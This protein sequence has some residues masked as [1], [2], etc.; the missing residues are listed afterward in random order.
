MNRSPV[1][2]ILF[3]LMAGIFILTV[4]AWAQP[5]QATPLLVV[6][7]GHG[8]TDGGVKINERYQEK[9]ATL[10]IA[11]LLQNELAR[12]AAV[13]VQ[14][15]RQA[16]RLMTT[17][18]RRKAVRALQPALFISLHV[19]GGFGKRSSGYEVYFPGFGS[20]GS[21]GGG[22]TEILKDMVRNKYLNESVRLAQSLQRNLEDVFPRKGRGLREAPIPILE[23][24]AMP[25][26]VVE[27]GFATNPE[28][29]AKIMNDKTQRAIAQALSRAVLEYL[30]NR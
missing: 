27:I 5:Q 24:L 23:G 18:E 25:A 10:A 15:T 1:E 6:D 20:K 7:P 29:R 14:L 3:L 16:D 30:N 17:S 28:D 22:T 9:D 12:S 8:G 19:N 21:G 26:V 11:S 2:T 4:P 13:T